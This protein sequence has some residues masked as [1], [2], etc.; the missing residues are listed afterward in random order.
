MGNWAALS[1][2]I[3]CLCSRKKAP[4]T[5]IISVSSRTIVPSSSITKISTIM[6]RKFR[7]RIFV[8][9]NVSL[10][11][12][13]NHN[14][15]NVLP[16]PDLHP[17]LHN[18]ITKPSLNLPDPHSPS[19]PRVSS[20][21]QQN[22]R[23]KGFIWGGTREPPGARSTGKRRGGCASPCPPAGTACC[24][25]GENKTRTIRTWIER[26]DSSFEETILRLKQE[27]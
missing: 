25:C 18:Q 8:T 2:W 22:L 26:Q 23:K 16:D 19:N 7:C 12:P 24:Y 21:Q 27:C 13:R 15:N 3:I 11:H 5:W 4:E 17:S 1:P 20:N 14:G 10:K 6:K 9:T